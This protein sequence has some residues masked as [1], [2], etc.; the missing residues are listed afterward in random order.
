MV[1][2]YLVSVDNCLI[3]VFTSLLDRLL[4]MFVNY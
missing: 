4:A 2:V 3:I 1:K